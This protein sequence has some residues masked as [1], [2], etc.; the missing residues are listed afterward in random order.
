MKVKLSV[1]GKTFLLGEYSVLDSG[2]C[3]VACAEPRFVLR[4]DTFSTGHCQGIS[5]ASP[6]GRWMRENRF[7]FASVGLEFL[8]PHHGQGGLGA[9][10][11]QFDLVYAWSLLQRSG[12]AELAKGLDP[13]ALWSCFREYSHIDEGQRPSGADVVVQS[14]GGI[15]LFSQ[16]PF[17]AKPLAWRFSDLGF[18]LVRT[19][20][21]LATHE[22]LKSVSMGALSAL[23]LASRRGVEAFADGDR[24]RFVAATNE[25]AAE[26]EDL[27]LVAP[28]TLEML[29]EFKSIPGI[30]AAKGCGAMGADVVLVLSDLKQIG[31]VREQIQ[32]RQYKIVGDISALAEG[33]KLEAELEPRQQANVNHKWA[34]LWDD[35]G[36]NV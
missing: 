36:S 2:P 27:Q 24:Q 8:D 11:A 17:V 29:T 21:K 23:K 31:V 14:L 6:A 28:R 35:G 34:N 30:L 13:Q 3:L 25:F 22:H 16:E 7:D 15:C 18:L 20:Q 12:F 33:L 5:P 19:G 9:S 4:V 32:S 1:P 10:S 26:L